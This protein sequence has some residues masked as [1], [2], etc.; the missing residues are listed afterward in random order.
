[1]NFKRTITIALL[2]ILALL[3]IRSVQA[4]DVVA[5]TSTELA[6]TTVKQTGETITEIAK[7]ISWFD[8]A[9]QKTMFSPMT[10]VKKIQDLYNAYP[11][12]TV[13][14]GL[15]GTGA[16]LGYCLWRDRNQDHLS[17]LIGYIEMDFATTGGKKCQ[18]AAIEIVDND[19]RTSFGT[20]D[21]TLRT[22]VH[23]FYST[24]ANRSNCYEKIKAKAIQGYYL[25]SY[26]TSWLSIHN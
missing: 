15:L 9:E 23:N 26:Y 21:E 7:N 22:L 20:R 4:A 5:S 16:L 1:M 13:A 19:Y 11:M 2:G 17:K 14:G 24:G 10:L 3:M 6:K 8:W 18:Q 12:P 25:R